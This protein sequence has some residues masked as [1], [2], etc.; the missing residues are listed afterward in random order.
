MV[1]RINNPLSEKILNL[2]CYIKPDQLDSD[3]LLFLLDNAKIVYEGKKYLNEGL[4][5]KIIAIEKYSDIAI[6]NIETSGVC[7]TNITV[8]CIV[9]NIFQGNLITCKVTNTNSVPLYAECI[10]KK[11]FIPFMFSKQNQKN[12]TVKKDSIIVVKIEKY[13][14][15]YNKIITLALF[16]DIATDEEKKEYFNNEYM[17]T[18]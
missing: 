10:G 14:V 11:I 2:Q 13:N 8:R 12:E 7:T 17:I 16:E 5:I 1:A 6:S 4:I 9:C 15:Q 18:K 3:I